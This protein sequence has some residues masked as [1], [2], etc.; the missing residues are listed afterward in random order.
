MIGSFEIKVSRRRRASYR[1]TLKRN[2][3]IVRGDSGTGKTTLYEMIDDFA[4]LGDRSGVSVQCERPCVA[5]S[6]SDWRHQL[7]S[8][9]NSIVFVD[10]G[11]Q[12]IRS[13]DFARAVRASSNYFVL[14]TRM[15]LPNL[16]YSVNEIYRIK[17]SGKYHTFER[18]YKSD[19][20]YRYYIR[21]RVK[22]KRDFDS[23]L[24]EDSKAGFEFFFARF[25]EEFSCERAM[26]NARVLQW[27]LDH[28]ERC[29]FVVADGAAFGAYADRVLKLQHE[30][31]D[32]FTVC[33][34]ESFEWLLLRSGL[35]KADGLAE[36]LENPERSIESSDYE[37]WEQFFTKVLS[38]ATKGTAF[39]YHKSK[40]AAAYMIPQ[41]ADKVLA[42]IACKN[43]Q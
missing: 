32:T 15:D 1:F 39:E 36:M 3:T 4:R 40:I 27:L 41:N 35:I 20:F 16:P 9:S 28:R 42:L 8:T 18:A 17:T 14:I 2:I 29:T 38:D 31:R 5:L 21:S 37:S 13:D 12:D 6:D 30:H 34:P 24:T 43:V 7:A 33:L 10:E 19:G 26:S 22:P 23:I 25:G 11:L